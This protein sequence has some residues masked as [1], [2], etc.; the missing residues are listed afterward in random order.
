M[1]ATEINLTGL[2]PSQLDEVIAKARAAQ[3]DA[4]KAAISNLRAELSERISAAGLKIEDVFP[5]GR[6]SAPRERGSINPPKYANP[7]NPNQTWAGRGKRPAWF[8]EQLQAGVAAES[9]LI[10]QV[11]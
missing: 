9:M 4:R 6:K 3:S 11:A 1:S 8:S 2:T 7:A 10:Q 5:S